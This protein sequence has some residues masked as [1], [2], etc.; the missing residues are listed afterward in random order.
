VVAT[1]RV[2]RYAYGIRASRGMAGRRLDVT[3]HLTARH[4]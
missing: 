3:L 4:R 1:V 2:D